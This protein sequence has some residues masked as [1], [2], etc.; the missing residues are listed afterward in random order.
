MRML[1][2]MVFWD[3][4]FLRGM[5]RFLRKRR[6]NRDQIARVL[7]PKVRPR[8]RPNAAEDRDLHQIRSRINPSRVIVSAASA[9]WASSSIL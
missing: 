2:L 6:D 3:E 5:F 7:G 9:I 1:A 8:I 4:P